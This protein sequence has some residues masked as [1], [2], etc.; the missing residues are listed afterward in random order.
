MLT[1]SQVAER[2]FVSPAT[3]DRM[4]ASGRFPAPIVVGAVRARGRVRRW[5]EQT[6]IDWINREDAQAQK[7]AKARR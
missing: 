1:A 4:I 6:V 7:A 2:I 5:R 3:L